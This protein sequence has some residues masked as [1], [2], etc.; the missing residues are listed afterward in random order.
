MAAAQGYTEVYNYSFVNEAAAH[1]FGFPPEAHV[2]VANPISEDQGLLRI[3]LLPGLYRNVVENAKHFTR[4]RLFE[5]G[6]EI[7]PRAESA[8]ARGSEER[9][10]E[11]I[12]HL[13][14]VH[15]GGGHKG[16][17]LMELK[18]LAECL[19]PGA[20]VRPAA[21]RPFEHPARS[22]EVFW[23][24]D[25][26]GRIFELHPSLADARAAVLDLD[27]AVTERLAAGRTVRYRPIRRYPASAFDLSVIAPRR[28]LVGDLQRS[29]E[30]LGGSDL[31]SI[32]FLRQ[33]EGAP[34]EEGT[35][36][37]SFR[38]VVGAEDRTLSSEEAGAVRQRIIGGMR[39]LGHD[40]RV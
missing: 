20:E 22:A 12:P 19:C 27:L 40:L 1:R 35:K 31:L 10:P 25:L 26:A 9:L 15:Y 14:A 37:V 28:A 21:A 18:R 23:Q 34:L 3:S 16:E 13:A 8:G 24:G 33:Y 4:F 2:R 38:L 7:H 39:A 5:I 11:E 17:G 6:Y 32:E 29:L 36:S 30:Q